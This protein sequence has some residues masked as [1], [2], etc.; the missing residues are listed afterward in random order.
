MAYK[1]RFHKTTLGVDAQILVGKAVAYTDDATFTAFVANAVEGEVAIVNNKTG[2][3]PDGLTAVAAG[4]EIFIALKRD[5]AIEKTTPFVLGATTEVEKIAYVA[6]VKHAITV[7][8]TAP[9]TIDKNTYGEIV[10]IETTPGMQPL[11][12]YNYGIT[13]KA[14]E[15]FVQF[16]TRL[17]ALINNDLAIEN[18]DKTRIVT[19]AV[20]NADDIVLTSKDFGTHFTVALRGALADSTF[21]VTAGFKEGSGHPTQVALAEL[22]GDIR[23]GVTTQYPDQNASPDEFGKAT[24]FVDAGAQYG[25]FKF[26]FNAVDRTRTL[27]HETRLNYIFLY[28]PSNGGANPYAKLATA[29]GV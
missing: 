24:S 15:T 16:V 3:I 14:G 11:P 13:G 27:D 25:A 1:N 26:K 18:A 7:A 22:Y 2:A 21:S 5:G 20:T 23:K 9:A 28:V 4:T 29:L 8:T 6:P 17:V 12:K 19:A 10:V